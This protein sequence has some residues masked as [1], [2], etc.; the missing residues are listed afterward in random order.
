MQKWKRENAIDQKRKERERQKVEECKLFW[1][2]KRKRK[3]NEE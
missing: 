2:T 3:N 1:V